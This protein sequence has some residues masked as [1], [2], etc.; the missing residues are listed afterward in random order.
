VACAR[1]R[2]HTKGCLPRHEGH[3]LV[4]QQKVFAVALRGDRTIREV[5]SSGVGTTIV[6]K[7]LALV[8]QEII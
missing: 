2:V 4:S 6:D 1:V 5:A 7:V 8:W 3:S